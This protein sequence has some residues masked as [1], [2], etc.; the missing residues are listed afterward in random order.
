[1]SMFNP[2]LRFAAA[3]AALGLSTAAAADALV[4]R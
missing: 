1:M 4:V 2:A 3:L